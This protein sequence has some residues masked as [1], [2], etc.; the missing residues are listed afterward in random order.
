[1][2]KICP[3]LFFYFIF[4]SVIAQSSANDQPAFIRDSLDSY[5]IK[6]IQDWVVPG[7]SIVIVKDNKVVWMKG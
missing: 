3:L 6:G 7:L 2:K 5:I 1:M 4:Q